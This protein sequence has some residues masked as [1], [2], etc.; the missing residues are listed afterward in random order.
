[1]PHVAIWHSFMIIIAAIIQVFKGGKLFKRGNYSGEETIQ[2]RKLL[3]I[4]RF[5]PRKLFKGGKY[6]REET[7]WGNTVYQSQLNRVRSNFF[8]GKGGKFNILYSKITSHLS[9]FSILPFSITTAIIKMKSNLKKKCIS[10]GYNLQRGGVVWNGPRIPYY[11]WNGDSRRLS[12]V[13]LCILSC[14]SY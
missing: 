9:I 10:S 8:S 3:I 7:I 13:G 12:F 14:S 6:S 2:G 1:M 4:R 5:W 11:Y